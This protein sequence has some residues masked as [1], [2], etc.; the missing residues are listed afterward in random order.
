MTKCV[1]CGYDAKG[2]ADMAHHCNVSL[3]H[4]TK[5][6]NIQPNTITITESEYAKLKEDAERFRDLTSRMQAMMD[7][8]IAA[9]F[10]IKESK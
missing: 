6:P 2:S 5:P 10:A 8:E 1:Y 7:A 3:S 4:H 9:A